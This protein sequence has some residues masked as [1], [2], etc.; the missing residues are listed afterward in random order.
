MILSPS[1]AGG[2][3]WVY[4]VGPALDQSGELRARSTIDLD[5]SPTGD[6][7]SEMVDIFLKEFEYLD[8]PPITRHPFQLDDTPAELLEGVPELGMARVIMVYH[9]EILYTLYFQPLG[10]PE[11][12]AD[13][14]LLFNTITTSFSFLP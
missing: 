5:S 9:D 1:E 12:Q 3:G 14:E 8:I 7:L 11:A 13:F 2:Q 10:F 4:V 6:N